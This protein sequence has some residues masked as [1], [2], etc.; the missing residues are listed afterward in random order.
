MG[1]IKSTMLDS[2]NDDFERARAE[3]N[4]VFEEM[5]E[6]YE[7][8]LLKHFNEEYKDV[9]NKIEFSSMVVVEKIH[10]LVQRHF[11]KEL[12]RIYRAD[13]TDP[14]MIARQNDL[15][16]D[17]LYATDLHLISVSNVNEFKLKEGIN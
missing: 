12:S 2:S 4:K 6:K 10:L 7:R 15:I 9:P 13:E 14:V 3:H 17:M 11:E 8:M 1:L 16:M 5:R